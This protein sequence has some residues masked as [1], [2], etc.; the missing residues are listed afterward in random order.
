MA[1]SIEPLQELER[2]RKI[3]VSEVGAAFHKTLGTV[4]I[5]CACVAL[6]AKNPD[7]STAF[8][9]HEGEI[10]EVSRALLVSVD[11]VE[12]ITDQLLELQWQRVDPPLWWE[13]IGDFIIADGFLGTLRAHMV[14]GHVEPGRV[15]K[16][17]H[18]IGKA[19]WPNAL[20]SATA[21]HLSK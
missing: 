17:A 8:V 20:Y 18:I 5:D 7:V 12:A 14:R 19:D 10:K 1:T 21:S 6:Q 4:E 11:S 13:D 9:K 16:N 3:K 15:V 2:C